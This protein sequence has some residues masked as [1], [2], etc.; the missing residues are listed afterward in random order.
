MKRFL[1]AKLIFGLSAT[2][3][4][5]EVSL[6]HGQQFHTEEKNYIDNIIEP[7]ESS[8]WI[9]DGENSEKPI[10]VL[11]N[12]HCGWSGKFFNDTRGKLDN[13]QLRWIPATEVSEKFMLSERSEEAIAQAFNQEPGDVQDDDFARSASRLNLSVTEQ[14]VDQARS[15]TQSRQLSFPMLIYRTEN[16]L[17]FISGNPDNIED[18]ISEV[19]QQSSSRDGATKGE[20][21]ANMDYSVEIEAGRVAAEVR[22]LKVRSHPHLDAP[23]LTTL[24]KGFFMETKGQV[25]VNDTTWHQVDVYRDGTPGYIKS[26]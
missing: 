7:L 13:A 10:Y 22:D 18:V 23:E 17:R 25:T 16:G 2:Y 6:E 3:A 1:A 15:L 14:A 8:V 24:E 9:S 26:R 20:E 19:A 5:A 11:F 4:Y 12:A 21:I